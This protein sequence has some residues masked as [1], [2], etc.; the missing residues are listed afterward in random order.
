MLLNLPGAWLDWFYVRISS[1]FYQF[2]LVSFLFMSIFRQKSVNTCLSPILFAI[3]MDVLIDRLR[4][5][6]FGCRLAGEFFGCIL[7]ADDVLRLSH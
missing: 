2:Y 6:R 5:F 7:Y 4:A 1:F 3:Y